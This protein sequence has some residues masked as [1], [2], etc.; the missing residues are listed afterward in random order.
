MGTGTE[1]Q[2]GEGRSG[3]HQDPSSPVSLQSPGHQSWQLVAATVHTA[4]ESQ[5]IPGTGTCI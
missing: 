4:L 3:L 5:E 2:L 1:Q